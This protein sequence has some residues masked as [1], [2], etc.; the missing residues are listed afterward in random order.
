MFEVIQERLAELR[1]RVLKNGN[2]S[3]YSGKK[4]KKLP[5]DAELC[6]ME[7]V[8][9]VAGEPWSDHPKCA[10]P[11]L[12]S[13]MISLNDNLPDADRDRLLKDFIPRLVGTNTTAEAE[14]RRSFLALDWMV[15]ELTPAYLDQVPELAD[16]A[17]RLRALPP[18]TSIESAQAA[19]E[20]VRIAG[21]AAAAEWQKRDAA[22]AAAWDAAWDAARAA[23]RDAAWA[24]AW[25]AA[26]DAAWD[27]ARAAARDAAWDAARAA[28]DATEGDYDAK[29]KAA[30]A[31]V[32][33][34]LDEKLRPMRESIEASVVAL[35]ERMIAAGA[36]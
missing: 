20:I 25:A 16:H 8:A 9:Y 14:M 5:T 36:A 32:K 21:G 6:V 29:Y 4:L 19:D 24:A 35:I 13:F 1:D 17:Q 22:W 12:T 7:A 23:A 34:M 18:L 27:A 10:S 28:A 33:P 31:A 30:Y 11:L 15:R 3:K 26:W 2:H